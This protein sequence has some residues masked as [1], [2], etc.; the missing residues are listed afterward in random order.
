MTALT[1]NQA[2]AELLETLGNESSAR[3]IEFMQAVTRLLPD[4]LSVGRP[5]AEAIKS[6]LIGELGFTSWADMIEAPAEQG[7]LGWNLSA[8]KAWR[9]AWA[10]AQEHPW[11]QQA[12]LS[13]SEI[14]TLAQ[15]CKRDGVPFPSS[16]ED[17]EALRSGRRTAQ[18][19]RRSDS[20]ASAA[21]RAENAEKAA[22]EARMDALKAQAEADTLRDQLSAAQE[23]AESLA[24]QLGRLSLERE[25]LAGMGL[26]Q[27]LMWALKG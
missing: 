20:V 8:W 18:E 22:H 11:L 12:G 23:R 25:R 4:V 6:S 13:S 26:W 15:D 24:Q 19:A 21:L 9:R 5:S 14:N 10:V 3:W 1:P 16:V 17:L 2:H 7:G 27:R